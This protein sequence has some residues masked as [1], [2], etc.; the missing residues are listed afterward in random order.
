MMGARDMVKAVYVRAQTF[1]RREQ[2]EPR[3]STSVEDIAAKSHPSYDWALLGA[4]TSTL[5][6]VSG[7]A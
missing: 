2:R 4:G 5:A 7:S 3:E 1:D 6:L